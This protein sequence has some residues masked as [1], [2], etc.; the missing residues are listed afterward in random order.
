MSEARR[1]VFL[2][3][4]SDYI[5]TELRRGRRDIAGRYIDYFNQTT[6][7]ERDVEDFQT[8]ALSTD[9]YNPVPSSSLVACRT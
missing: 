9:R 8:Y 6:G 5:E 4:L 1:Q 7:L 3:T 2:R